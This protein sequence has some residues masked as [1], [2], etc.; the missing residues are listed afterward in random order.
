M[1][2]R[3]VVAFGCAKSRAG[4]V[5]RATARAKRPELALPDVIALN[6]EAKRRRTLSGRDSR[7]FTPST[8]TGVGSTSRDDRVRGQP[9]R[10]GWSSR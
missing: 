3:T 10:A 8:C 2:G 5:D 9:F 1:T 6:A 7:R 4:I